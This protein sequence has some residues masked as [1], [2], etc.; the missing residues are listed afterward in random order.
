MTFTRKACSIRY[1]FLTVMK[2]ASNNKY[3]KR[4]KNQELF[5]SQIRVFVDILSSFT[6]CPH[7]LIK[8][9]TLS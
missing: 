7:M 3:I 5:T 4:R 2:R 8:Q 6:E 1:I 9:K